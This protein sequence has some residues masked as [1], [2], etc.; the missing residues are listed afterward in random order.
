MKKLSLISI[1]LSVLL[2]LTSCMKVTMSLEVDKDGN[3]TMEG[4]FLFSKKLAQIAEMSGEDTGD[5]CSQVTEDEMG[6]APPEGADQVTLFE[7]DDWCGYSFIGTFQ[8][9]KVPDSEDEAAPSFTVAGDEITFSMEMDMGELGLGEM[10]G[11]SGSDDI[12][13]EQMMAIFDIP[14]PEFV[15]AVTL[16]GEVTD[17]NADSIEGS[18][19]T[20]NLDLMDDQES[21]SLSATANMSSGDSGISN[22]L[23]IGIAVA[24]GLLTAG[25]VARQWK[26]S[27]NLDGSREED[28][29]SFE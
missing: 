10:A 29:P 22:G 6:V 24:V 1:L 14:E 25:F 9:F 2:I 21:G 26:S 17:H 28:G 3:G 5:F 8:D 15:I 23:I 4:S 12:D 11:D 19:L 7:D 13:F 27:K 18:T 16:P 20:W